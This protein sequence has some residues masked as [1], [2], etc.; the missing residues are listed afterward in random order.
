MLVNHS[1]VFFMVSTKT[2]C[3]VAL[4]GT[5]DWAIM[6]PKSLHVY[7]GNSLNISSVKFPKRLS[8]DAVKQL[9]KEKKNKDL[10]V[11]IPG[12]RSFFQ[13]GYTLLSGRGFVSLVGSGTIFKLNLAQGE[14]ISIKRGNLLATTIKDKKEFSDG[15]FVAQ[16]LTKSP[17]LELNS[18]KQ[19]RIEEVK[20]VKINPDEAPSE[21]TFW[22]KA[23]VFWKSFKSAMKSNSNFAYASIIGNGGYITVK[24]PRTL[25]IQTNSGLDQYVLS[26]SGSLGVGLEAVDKFIKDKTKFKQPEPTPGDNFSVVTIKNGKVEYRNTPD[27][28]DEVQRIENLKKGGKN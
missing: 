9:N 22:F 16:I 17:E 2:F 10:P 18:E 7:T 5:V 26:N 3:N 24:G 4:D 27:F 12:L 21:D 14:E 8:G 19:Q 13:T 15:H 1:V 20:E 6:E 23:N 28:Q 11:T 25:L